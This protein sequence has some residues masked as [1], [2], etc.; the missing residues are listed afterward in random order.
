M[1]TRHAT[2]PAER[3]LTITRVFDAPRALVFRLW[4]DPRH[5]KNWWGPTD[6]P[7]SHLEMDVRPGG[8]WR[9]CLVST[10]DGREL[11]QHG[12]FREVVAPE[13]LV[14]TFV[15]DEEGERGIE[16]LVTVSFAEQGGKTH[17]TF[18]HAPFQ[19]DEERDGHHGGWSS[20]FDRLDQYLLLPTHE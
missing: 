13:R 8:A 14:F 6:Y 10:A 16:T 17:M 1:A 15:W 9:G 20:T 5:A 4:T 18:R 12:V 3:E 7:A 19:S 2:K 11:W